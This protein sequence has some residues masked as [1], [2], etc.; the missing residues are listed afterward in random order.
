MQITPR[1]HIPMLLANLLVVCPLVLAGPAAAT[2]SDSTRTPTCAG[3]PAT[4]VGTAASD[5][6]RGTPRRDVVVARDG[7]DQI[8]TG[9]GRDLVCAGDGF[10]FLRLGRGVDRALGSAGDDTVHGGDGADR[11]KGQS[12]IDQLDGGAGDDELFGGRGAGIIIEGFIGGPGDDRLIG[13][14]GLDTT[15]FFNS[16]RGV[17]VNLSRG[18][19]IGQG[20]DVLVNI[21]GVVGSNSA[22]TIVGDETGNGLFGQAGADVIRGGGSGRIVDGTSDVIGG[23]DG[24]DTLIAG[25]GQDLVTFGRLLQPVNVDLAAGTA[26]GQGSDVIRGAEGVIGSRL[27]DDLVGGPLRDYLAGST[28]DDTINGAGGETSPSI[29]TSSARSRPASAMVWPKGRQRAS[30]RS[31]TSKTSGE[32]QPTIG[33]PAATD[34]T[35]CV[36]SPETI[37]WP[38]SQA[39]ICSTAASAPTPAPTDQPNSS[40]ARPCR[41][42]RSG[43]PQPA[44]TGPRGSPLR[45]RPSRGMSAARGGRPAVAHGPCGPRGS[46]A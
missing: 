30:T 42:A 18:S 7:D 39:S 44:V 3:E 34:P 41:P 12:G 10:D 16:P 1:P 19:A 5:D 29:V 27:D 38:G 26:I 24:D 25:P 11:L 31:P 46:P 9:A 37:T 8:H 45:R 13:G 15:L 33:S 40:G 32:R 23:D 21:E 6:L 36:A 35:P 17:R 28:G 14:P 20:V 22:D 4:V 43:R 2:Q